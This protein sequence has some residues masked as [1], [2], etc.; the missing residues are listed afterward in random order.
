MAPKPAARRPAGS[1][2]GGLVKQ[3]KRLGKD[4]SVAVAAGLVA[5]LAL[6]IAA[7]TWTAAAVAPQ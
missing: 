4:Y 6:V 2:Q 5:L 3:A 7:L 1:K